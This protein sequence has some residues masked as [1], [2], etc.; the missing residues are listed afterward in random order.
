MNAR[1]I[2]A[3]FDHLT[4]KTIAVV[5][6]FN[7]PQA[8]PVLEQIIAY[9][10]GG[11]RYIAPAP[12][13]GVNGYAQELQDAFASSDTVVVLDAG[14][15]GMVNAAMRESLA[16]LA[17]RNRRVHTLARSERHIEKFRHITLCMTADEVMAMDAPFSL[18]G[19]GLARL[20]HC[21][22]H[23][24]ERN[25]R[26]VFITLGSEGVLLCASG[27][28]KKVP[29]LACDNT[30]ASG[31]RR[32]IPPVPTTPKSGCSSTCSKPNATRA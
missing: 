27:R 3:I 30:A 23:M 8:A 13:S 9:G 14:D 1:R 10:A 11:I 29:A 16:E 6:D 21:G 20:V 31:P 19:S 32:G 17:R 15:G 18:R 28:A 7:T 22:I 4:S 5:G 12:E 24:A 26:P 25:K 2:R